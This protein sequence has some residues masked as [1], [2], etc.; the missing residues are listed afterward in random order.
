M[1]AFDRFPATPATHLRLWSLLAAAQ[2]AAYLASVGSRKEVERFGFLQDYLARAREDVADAGSPH[3]IAV[4][5]LEAIAAWEADLPAEAEAW[6]LRRLQAGGLTAAHVLALALAGLVEDDARFGALFA[7]L[8]PSPDDRLTVGLLSDCLRA[9]APDAEDLGWQVARQLLSAGLLVAVDPERPRASWALRVP[10]PVWD[11][12]GGDLAPQPAP[13][14]RYLP[15]ESFPPL[16]TLATSLAEGVGGKIARAPELLMGA[17]D[18]LVIRGM[19]GSGRLQCAGSIAAALGM[20]AIVLQKPS[21]AA[22]AAQAALMGPLCVLYGALPV[23]DLDLDAGDNLEVPSLPGYRGPRVFILGKEGSLHG[24]AVENC[25]VISLPLQ[26]SAGRRLQWQ[27]ALAGRADG[28]VLDQLSATLHLTAGN[29]ERAARL[30]LAYAT[31]DGRGEVRPADVRSANRTMNQ[32]TLDSLAARIETDNSPEDLVVSDATQQ[33]LSNLLMRCRQ[34]EA[35]IERLGRGF[36]TSTNRGVRAL[37]S[38]PS[39]TGKTLAARILAG[40]MGLDLYR[41]DLSAVVNKYIGE[42]ER[43]LARVF[44]RAEERDVVL[45]LDE[46][47]SLMTGRTEVRTSNDRYA[48]METN[49]LLQR[50]ESYEGVLV[51]TTNAPGRIDKAFQRRIDVH[52]EF[53]APDSAERYRIWELHLPAGHDVPDWFLGSVSTH[54]ALSGGQI[55]NAALHATFLAMQ[56]VRPLGREHLA[57]AV[58]REYRK[59]GAT[60][61]LAALS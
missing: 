49:Y 30:A 35:V 47:D 57:D 12:M 46:G 58:A 38:G 27:A 60:P 7:A 61:P 23:I 21:E 56:D 48:N 4:A 33:E 32:D 6:P 25:A 16:E 41:V 13:G 50:I 11:A 52:V 28:A 1:S 37:F 45:L 53:T 51:V 29:I 17:V 42:T 18:G 54:C 2:V 10:Q 24:P 9:T 14:L 26:G 44:A 40:A 22:L 3:D 39:G 55:R 8:Q 31:L 59:L 36:G 5:T 34:R 43:N 19:Q 20:G 15:A